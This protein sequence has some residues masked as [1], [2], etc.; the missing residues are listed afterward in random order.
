[1]P[2][3]HQIPTSGNCYKVRLA[4]HVLDI[5]LTLKNYPSQQHGGTRTPE[6]LKINPNGK[7]PV[8]ELDDGRRLPESGAILFYLSEGTRLQPQDRWGRAEMLQWMFFEQYSHEP[9][10]AVARYLGR[11]ALPAERAA[12]ADR[13]PELMAKGN[14]ALAVMEGRLAACDW[15]AG[16]AFSVADIALYAYTHLA[17]EGGFRLSDYPHIRRWLDRVAAEPGYFPIIG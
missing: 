1:M 17:E 7:V 9:N 12:K 3:L 10:I 8:L 16:G 2:I 14:A 15:F 5:P 4:A 13:L 6:F 11:F